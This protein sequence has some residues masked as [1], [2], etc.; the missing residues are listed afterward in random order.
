ME[1]RPF[2][3]EDRP[4]LRT[5]YL[6]S[7]KASWHWLDQQAWQLEDFDHI[8]IGERVWVAIEQQRRVGFAAV[9]VSDNFLHSLYIG[10]EWQRRGIGSALLDQVEATFTAHGA[11][12]CLAANSAALS[13][14][15]QRGWQMVSY[16]ESEQGKYVL[17]HLNKSPGPR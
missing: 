5:L 12:K 11:L 8:I 13:F 6:A 4:F 9:N 14:Y 15:Q 1:I 2:S 3:E 10:P 7:R 16:G 17:M